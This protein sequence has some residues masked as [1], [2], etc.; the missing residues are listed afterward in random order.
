MKSMG[1]AVRL[2]GLEASAKLKGPG[3]REALI[4]APFDNFIKS[5]GEVL[6][7]KVTP[8]DEVTELEGVVRP[9][10]AI[11]VNGAITGHVELK[12]PG[13]SLDPS[14]Y[15]KTT[16]NY[17]QWQKLKEL[18]NLIY[19]NG[20]EW[21]LWRN[22]EL[23]GQ[24]VHLMGAA[25]L[26]KAGNKLVLGVGFEELI[27]D[28]LRWKP[29][30][31]TTVARLV[32]TVAPLTRL[33]KEQVREEL[34]SERKRQKAGASPDSLLFIGLRADW[35]Q[36]LFP[37][38]TDEEFADGYAQTITFALLLA[39]AEGI[40]LTNEKLHE[41][42]KDLHGSHS[43]M[44]KALQLLTDQLDSRFLTS[45]ELLIRVIS[46]VDWDKI[47]SGKSD[48]YLHLYEHF[49]QVYDYAAR[50]KT[51]SY[52]T[53]VEVVDEMVRLTESVLEDVL[54]R[55]DKFLDPG[56]RVIDPAMGTGTYPLSIMR[57][58]AAQARLEQGPGAVAEALAD[59]VSRLYGFE[60]Q[61]GPFSVAELRL[62]GMLKDFGAKLPSDGLQLFVT[63]TLSDP[64]ATQT[65]M[66]SALQLIAQ[67]SQRANE[68]KRETNVQVIIGNPPYKDDAAGLGSWVEAGNGKKGA[69][70]LMQD[71]KEPGYGVYERKAKNLYVFFWRWGLWKAFESTM[72]PDE[73]D[74]DTGVVCFITA[75]G[76][77][78]G[79]GFAG[80]RRHMREHCSKGWIIDL[81][82]EGKRPPSE[83]AIFSI[84]TPVGIGI[85]IREPGTPK[86][87]PADINYVSF[88]GT[89]EAKYKALSQLTLDS[90]LWQ[91]VRSAW[92][93]PFTPAAEGSWDDYPATEEIFPWWQ[94]GMTSARTWVYAPTEQ[95][96][97][98]RWRALCL[99][100]GA[101]DKAALF[102][103]TD[104]THLKKGHKPLPGV[105]SKL[106]TL[107]PVETETGLISPPIVRC[108]YRSFDRQWVIADP[109]VIHR[110]RRDLW[111]ARITG[112]IFVSEAHHL[113]G[114]P[115]PALSFTTLIPD[116]DHFNHR[117]GRVLPLLHPNGDANIAPGLLSAL[118]NAFGHEVV[119]E[120]VVAYVA[121]IASHPGYNDYFAQERVTPGVRLPITGESELWT[122]AV[123]LGKRVVWLHTYGERFASAERS[124]DL[125]K[126]KLDNSPIHQ[127]AVG[128]LPESFAYDATSRILSV[129][130]QGEWRNVAPEVVDYE[131]GGK[132]ILSMWLKYR[133]AQPI[134]RGG[135]GLNSIVQ[136]EWPSAW[137]RELNEL[138]VALTELVSL[139]P[140]QT[141][142][143]NEI[144]SS[145]LLLKGDLEDN[146]VVWP[147]AKEAPKFDLAFEP[148][149]LPIVL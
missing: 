97:E 81:T 2:L 77:L 134:T 131:V 107:E 33:I 22:G 23:V 136:T 103:E 46:A 37:M 117:A 132:N 5:C 143:L 105:K 133:L 63:N 142:L 69:P 130:K 110:P 35:R 85:F 51:G 92:T 127:V 108:G 106:D 139:E 104:S 98:D 50:K 100:D 72:R 15:G 119:A 73:P 145:K 30:P 57:S 137:T 1:D 9:D 75:E 148:G 55:P 28:F 8:H 147:K 96:L 65:S 135:S 138:L 17:R 128:E 146:G 89:R 84:E 54:K 48:V 7:L 126:P 29:S 70:N 78:T 118:S 27:S 43:L 101:E 3:Q 94:Q 68:I 39:Q 18:P 11:D 40:D 149:Q 19:S 32:S 80:M 21:R 114:E 125:L 47:Q 120:D 58:A 13:V 24:P 6:Q 141:E 113:R 129:G 140:L 123:E 76:Y 10:Y 71:F 112:Q 53:P 25:S 31:I 79:P 91:K 26:D 49:L 87:V 60:I 36:L 66:G 64:E 93:A 121:G 20:I 42:G 90:P 122:R 41:I 115:G 83:N 4:R 38:A 109:R 61:S 34:Q 44:G 14:T 88:H 99:E 67:Q 56:V 144:M 16:H 95:V 86:S 124:S 52:Y 62:S 59:L 74:S 82:P 45:V 111:S 102:R 12:A 116:M